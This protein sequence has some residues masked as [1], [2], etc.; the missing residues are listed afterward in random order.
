[1]NFIVNWL[2]SF[3][4]RILSM[5]SIEWQRVENEIICKSRIIDCRM[6]HIC[7]ISH[8]QYLYIVRLASP[9]LVRNQKRCESVLT[10][11]KDPENPEVRPMVISVDVS[12]EDVLE[13]CSF[14]SHKFEIDGCVPFYTIRKV[15]IDDCPPPPPPP[16]P[17]EDEVNIYPSPDD[18]IN[19]PE[20][21]YQALIKERRRRRRGGRGGRRHRHD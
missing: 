13:A 9:M 4:T 5:N 20:A 10:S 8:G 12:F 3:E 14:E 2:K 21:E 15:E 11:D 19:I 18:P 7:T 16:P 1:M 17:M 6:P